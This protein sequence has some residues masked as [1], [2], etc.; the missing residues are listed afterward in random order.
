MSQ[1]SRRVGLVSPL[2]PQIGG[3]AAVGQWLLSHEDELGVEY[4]TFDLHRPAGGE[5]GGRLHL[6][7]VPRQARLFSGFLTWVPRAPSL[8]HY[9]VAATRT[10]LARDILFLAVLRLFGRKVVAHVH[11]VDPDS[12][13]WRFAIRLVGR[14]TSARI[15]VANRS[16]AALVRVGV[17]ADAIPNPVTLASQNGKV[18]RPAAPESLLT[19]GTYGRRKG[20]FELID[21]LA[22]LRS[23]G[24]GARLALVGKEEYRGEER[25]L[26]A[27]C[28]ERG[29]GTSVTFAGVLVGDALCDAYRQAGVFCL[30]SWR[31]GL[32]TAILEAMAFGL[33]VVTTPVGGIADVVRD[34]ET[35]FLVQP[36][37]PDGLAEVLA[38]LIADPERARAVGAR[39]RAEVLASAGPA[40]VATA[41]R[42][43]YEVHV[44]A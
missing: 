27:R 42:R 26:E 33:P 20:T 41:W 19:V 18:R 31:E 1:Q 35:G 12:R 30:P 11:V 2:P 8:V 3:V 32:P 21:A 23:R 28:S 22:L 14:L 43:A 37:D 24:V 40:A 39:A 38:R 36:G 34:G 4:D 9:A 5:M 6:A 10:G 15:A 44:C 29:L 17:S 25:L 13:Y 16:A 7:A